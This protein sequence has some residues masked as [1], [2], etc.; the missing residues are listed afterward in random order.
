MNKEIVLGN[1]CLAPKNARLLC[2]D[3]LNVTE[4]HLS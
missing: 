4:V 1:L 3:L 2:M